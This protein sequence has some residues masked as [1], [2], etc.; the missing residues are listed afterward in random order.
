MS[1][2]S[3]KAVME[4][5]DATNLPMMK[6]KAALT[7]AGGDMQKAIE[8]L[9]K[10]GLAATGKFA[11]RDTP[12]GAI[13]MHLAA[14]KGVLVQLG[15]QT[16]FVGSNET[17]KALVG[18]LAEVA[19][20]KGCDS[21]EA[22]AAQQ[23]DGQAVS[24]LLAGNMQK[25]G[26]NTKL[27]AVKQLAGAVVAGYNHGGRIAALVAGSGDA[28]KLKQIAL[29]V[30]SA[31]PAPVALDRAAVDKA[32]V[33]KEREIIAATPEVAAKPEAMRPKIVEGK[34][35]RFFKENVLLEQEMLIDAEKGETVEKYA[36]RNG[37]TLTG[38]ARLQVGK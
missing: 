6:C 19:A 35:G 8:H 26:E 16:D 17:F 25:M 28:A 13:A 20:A 18:R 37:L 23:I 33:D 10:Q 11:D 38:F 24:E 30:A 36:K 22:L 4:L 1:E 31:S 12:N 9:R 32:L 2:I 29:H 15:C 14:G 34:L 3:A 7:A 5:R 21:V 27:V